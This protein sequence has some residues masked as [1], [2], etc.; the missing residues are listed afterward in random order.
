MSR[1]KLS[2][3][4]EFFDVDLRHERWKYDGDECDPVNVQKSARRVLLLIKKC[5]QQARKNGIQSETGKPK[6]S[7]A[8]SRS[9]LES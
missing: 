8:P 4:F 1:V 9:I 5:T 7:I 3:E 2:I 6:H